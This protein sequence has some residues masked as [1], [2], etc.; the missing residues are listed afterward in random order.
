MKRFRFVIDFSRRPSSSKDNKKKKNKANKMADPIAKALEDWRDIDGDAKVPVI[1]DDGTHTCYCCGEIRSDLYHDE[2]PFKDGKT[3]I[4]SL[5]T[6]CRYYRKVR[7]AD[8]VRSAK[9]HHRVSHVEVRVDDREW[10]GRC[11]TLRS[12]RYHE[13]LLSGQSPSGNGVCGRCIINTEKKRE[14]ARLRLYYDGWDTAKHDPL[15]DNIQIRRSSPYA[16]TP[17]PSQETVKVISATPS[18]SDMKAKADC[19]KQT[20]VAVRNCE[21]KSDSASGGVAAHKAVQAHHVHLGARKVTVE[22]DTSEDIRNPVQAE[23]R[24]TRHQLPDHPK[25][26]AQA[27]VTSPSSSISDAT[28]LG[29]IE[30]LHEPQEP[31]KEQ[32]EHKEPRKVPDQPIKIQPREV[33]ISAPAMATSSAPS[34]NVKQDQQPHAPSKSPKQQEYI[35]VLSDHLEYI[36]VLSD[37]LMKTQPREE[38]TQIPTRSTS[39]Q[40]KQGSERQEAQECRDNYTGSRTGFDKHSNNPPEPQPR[41][42]TYFKMKPRPTGKADAEQAPPPRPRGVFNMNRFTTERKAEPRPQRPFYFMNRHPSRQAQTEQQAP[43]PRARGV[44]DMYWASAEGKAEQARTFTSDGKLFPDGTFGGA[45][46]SGHAHAFRS[47]SS[48]GTSTRHRSSAHFASS[49]WAAS[50]D[51]ASGGNDFVHGDSRSSGQHRSSRR[52]RVWEV[53]SDEAEEI[54]HGH[55]KLVGG[56]GRGNGKARKA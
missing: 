35:S 7:L 19:D 36:R 17:T 6:Q 45:A 3:A 47:A 55:A 5:C 43:P 54:E 28:T 24:N 8:R 23:Q 18:T 49:A 16:F 41:E 11:G 48:G 9:P 44:S 34:G 56:R 52:A 40:T 12:N 32:K 27:Q 37:R 42:Q 31:P 33:P 53:D 26:K 50:A 4:P 51:H 30:Q 29:S 46:A 13:K 25:L 1:D 10:C 2:H 38:P 20:P 14:H 39:G 22:D 21:N 15:L